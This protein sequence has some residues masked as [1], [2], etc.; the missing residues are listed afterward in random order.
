MKPEDQV[1][2]FTGYDKPFATNFEG[3][4]E[5]SRAMADSRRSIVLAPFWSFQVA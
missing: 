5:E 2:D 4:F 3:G 1:A